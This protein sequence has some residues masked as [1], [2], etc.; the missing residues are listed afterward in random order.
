MLW[1]GNGDEPETSQCIEPSNYRFEVCLGVI[2]Q[3]VPQ[4]VKLVA[5]ALGLHELEEL[6]HGFDRVRLYSVW[7]THVTSV[8]WLHDLNSV[9]GEPF[10]D[11]CLFGYIDKIKFY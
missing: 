6:I 2:V 1:S 7:M 8:V 5:P 11:C 10:I 3:S 9:L 4:R